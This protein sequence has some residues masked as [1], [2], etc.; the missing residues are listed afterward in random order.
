MSDVFR[1]A[2]RPRKVLRVV[3][4]ERRWL[5]KL[6]DQPDDVFI[7]IQSVCYRRLHDG[8]HLT[9]DL[10]SGLRVCKQPVFPSYYQ[11]FYSFALRVLSSIRHNVPYPQLFIILNICIRTP[12]SHENLGIIFL[13]FLMLPFSWRC[14]RNVCNYNLR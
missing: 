5:W 14:I 4:S 11:V 7:G 8:E 13:R 1:D 3:E 12:F 6:V 9:G 10:R 2:V